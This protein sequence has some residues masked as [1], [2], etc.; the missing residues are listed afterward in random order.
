MTEADFLGSKAALFIGPKILVIQRDDFDHIP[1]PGFW[2]FPGGGRENGE[3]AVDCTLRETEEEVGLRLQPSQLIWS[4]QYYRAG[5]NA[6]FF[7]AHLPLQMAG[8]VRLGS[9]GQ[10]WDLWDPDI[11]LHH[12]LAIPPFARQLR[13]YLNGLAGEDRQ[14]A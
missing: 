12:P 14:M 4:R 2:D 8:Q 1:Y 7:V 9:E 3:S 11:Y 13:D 5:G 10:R 6:W